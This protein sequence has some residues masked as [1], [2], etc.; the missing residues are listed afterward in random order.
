MATNRTPL[1][2]PSRSPGSATSSKKQEAAAA[3]TRVAH[4]NPAHSTHPATC[5]PPGP[6]RTDAGPTPCLWESTVSTA[7]T[8]NLPRR[9][10]I[11]M[12][13][14]AYS[15]LLAPSLTIFWRLPIDIFPNRF[16]NSC[17]ARRCRRHRS[18]SQ[19]IIF[20]VIVRWGLTQHPAS[21]RHCH[22]VLPNLA[23]NS[24]QGE[25]LASD[26]SCSSRQDIF[27]TSFHPTTYRGD[28][29]THHLYSGVSSPTQ[30]DSGAREQRQQTKNPHFA[31]TE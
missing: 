15:G 31:T 25:S 23:R 3:S 30:P 8:H 7:H 11:Y 21:S 27:L 20:F 18:F 17:P 12:S 24:S 1:S 5:Y 26:R 13:A 16:P 19:L 29:L 4:T 28:G 9:Q 10:E 22:Q 6:G 14:H 2:R